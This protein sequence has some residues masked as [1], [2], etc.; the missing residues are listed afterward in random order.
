[1]TRNM[2]LIRDILLAIEAK[3]PGEIIQ[4]FMLPDHYTKAEVVYHLRLANEARYLDGLVDFHRDGAMLALH[5]LTNKGH[6][7]LDAIRSDTVWNKTKEKLKEVGGT[8]ALETV[9]SLAVSI[10]AK[11]LAM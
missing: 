11:L 8:A 5:G 9:K 7:F 6:D 3:P 10:G 1:M 2:D 4:T